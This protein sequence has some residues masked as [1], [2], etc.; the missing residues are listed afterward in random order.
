MFRSTSCWVGVPDHACTDMKRRVC[1]AS[2]PL[3]RGIAV[4]MWKRTVLI[5]AKSNFSNAYEELH[6]TPPRP[7]LRFNSTDNFLQC[8]DTIELL[9]GFTTVDSA[10]GGVARAKW[11]AA[12]ESDGSWCEITDS[13][14]HSY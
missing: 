6:R 11:H 7:R 12:V 14:P 8:Q 5:S 4:L 13:D 2:V 1:C 10:A 3:G 9:E